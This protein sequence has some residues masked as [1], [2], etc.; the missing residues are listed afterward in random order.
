MGPEH[1]EIYGKNLGNSVM[2]GSA[3]HVMHGFDATKI[4]SARSG[5]MANRELR[6]WRMAHLFVDPLR[7]RGNINGGQCMRF[8]GGVRA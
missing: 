7:K 5:T 6:E 1:K 2:D 4:A 3:V 8:C